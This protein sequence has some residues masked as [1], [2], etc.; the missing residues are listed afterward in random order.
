VT[1]LQDHAAFTHL[2]SILLSKRNLLL[3]TV[4][5]HL[6]FLLNTHSQTVLCIVICSFAQSGRLTNITERIALT[7]DLEWLG[8][9][10][11][12]HFSASL[13]SWLSLIFT[14]QQPTP[15]AVKADV[16]TGYRSG[17]GRFSDFGSHIDT[18]LVVLLVVVGATR[19]EIRI[20][21]RSR[22]YDLT[23]HIQGGGHDVIS[24]RKILPYAW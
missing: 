23:S 24:R 19:N 7:F 2:R 22:I 21:S 8:W 3:Y 14:L 17:A 4:Q 13:S 15:Q 10:G 9:R 12:Y 6:L 11:A 20:D 5:N 18:Y 1:I 16:F